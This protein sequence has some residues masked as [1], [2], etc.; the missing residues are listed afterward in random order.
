MARRLSIGGDCRFIQYFASI[1]GD[2]N[3]ARVT[4]HADD[5][6]NGYSFLSILY[7]GDENYL[8]VQFLTRFPRFGDYL[9]PA[10]ASPEA[11]L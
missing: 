5:K 3:L 9:E 8:R 1:A 6:Q 10:P 4:V 7:T 2:M 11:G